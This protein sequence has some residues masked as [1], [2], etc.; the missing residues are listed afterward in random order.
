ME[1]GNK[2]REKLAG[3]QPH[4]SSETHSVFWVSIQFAVLQ[5]VSC[6]FQKYFKNTSKVL[7]ALSF[8]DHLPSFAFATET[9]QNNNNKGL[10][11]DLLGRAWDWRGFITNGF[12]T[13]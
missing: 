13:L 5:L 11:K 1:I 2:A 4:K 6:P 10:W 7:P 3:S 9:K 12:S 8:Y